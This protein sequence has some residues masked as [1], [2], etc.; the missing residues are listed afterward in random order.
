MSSY[1]NSTMVQLIG[2]S[3]TDAGYSLENFNSTMV[4]LIGHTDFD[5]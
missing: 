1:F 3:G 5:C 2:T 4:Q